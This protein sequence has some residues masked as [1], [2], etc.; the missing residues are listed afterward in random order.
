MKQHLIAQNFFRNI[1]RL[2]F[3]NGA[4]LLWRKYPSAGLQD[5]VHFKRYEAN[6]RANPKPSLLE[7]IPYRE[8]HLD[9]RGY[10][11]SALRFA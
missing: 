3:L 8:C 4:R 6:S 7:S 10:N 5:Q 9:W 1:Q 2:H 11:E